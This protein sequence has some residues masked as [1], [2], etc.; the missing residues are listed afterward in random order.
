MANTKMNKNLSVAMLIW[1]ILHLLRESS[2]IMSHRQKCLW[3]ES[4]DTAC[5]CY[6]QITLLFIFKRRKIQL[7]L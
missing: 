6:H 1:L 2:K 3:L 7:L 5:M 4:K